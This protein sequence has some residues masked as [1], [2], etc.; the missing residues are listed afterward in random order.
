MTKKR[1][2]YSVT[3]EEFVVAWNSSETAEEAAGKLA[4]PKAIAQ[5][6]ATTYRRMGI[7]LKKMDRRPKTSLNLELLNKLANEAEKKLDG[8]PSGRGSEISKMVDSIISKMAK[9]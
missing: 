4:M 6:R 7:P 8:K 5:A 2:E 1:N 9:K 3:P